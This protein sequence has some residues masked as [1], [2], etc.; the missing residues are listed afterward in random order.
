[1]SRYNQLQKKNEQL[2]ATQT[3]YT[4]E[5]D[6]KT[7]ELTQYQKDMETKMISI[8]NAMSN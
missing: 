4:E 8:N 5:L 1:M 7:K 2:N 3:L 6:K